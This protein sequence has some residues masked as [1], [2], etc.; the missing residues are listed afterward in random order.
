MWTTAQR[1]FGEL[2][3]R[4]GEHGDWL[5]I[6]DLKARSNADPGQADDH[7]PPCHC[8]DGT[9]FVVKMIA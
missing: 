5:V 4:G 8:A 1:L 9:S 3:K 7:V 6:D 2:G